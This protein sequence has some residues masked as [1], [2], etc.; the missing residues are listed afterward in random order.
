MID[1]YQKITLTVNGLPFFIKRYRF[2]YVTY[3]RSYK[4]YAL[5]VRI[6]KTLWEM[7]EKYTMQ[8][9]PKGSR[10]IGIRLKDNKTLLNRSIPHDKSINPKGRCDHSKSVNT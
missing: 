8:K 5:N 4:R 6:W 1:R 3:I 10:H 9:S 2:I 7:L